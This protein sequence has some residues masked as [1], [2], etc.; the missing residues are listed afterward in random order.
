MK[1]QMFMLNAVFFFSSN[2][3]FATTIENR[4]RTFMTENQKIT[5][6]AEL[7]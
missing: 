6:R 1:L 3:N 7:Y 2:Q 5:V 4:L